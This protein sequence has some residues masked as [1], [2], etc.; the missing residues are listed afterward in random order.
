MHKSLFALTKF[1]NEIYENVE[2]F[3]NSMFGY[4]IFMFMAATIGF[5]PSFLVVTKTDLLIYP[6]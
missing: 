3:K 2:D 6:K 4:G 5:H 1:G